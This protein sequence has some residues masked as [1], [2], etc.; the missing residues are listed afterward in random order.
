MPSVWAGVE[1]CCSLA[2]TVTKLN[3]SILFYFVL[4]DGDWD[5]GGDGDAELESVA[6][7]SIAVD[8]NV[9]GAD[10]RVGL[11]LITLSSAVTAPWS[12]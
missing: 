1:V 9:A 7:S 10:G 6:V 3:R 12:F 11:L 4:G 8:N 2:R 5:V